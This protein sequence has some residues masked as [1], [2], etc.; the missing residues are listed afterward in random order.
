[1][2][3][4]IEA[5]LRQNVLINA[6]FIGLVAYA[7]SVALPS[8]PIDRYPNFSFGQ[9]QV[10]TRYPGASAFDVERLVTKKIEDAIRGMDDIEWVSSVS[11]FG[12]SEVLVKFI[13]DTD[14]KALYDELRLRVLS[15]QNQLPTI[16]GDP[17]SPLFS[18]IETDTWLP[19]VQVSLLN[20]DGGRSLDKRALTL[21]GRDLRNQLESIPGVKRV[22]L[23]GDEDQQFTLALNS[24]RLERYRVSFGEV[25]SALEWSGLSLPAGVARTSAGERTIVVDSRYRAPEEVFDVV[26]RRDGDGAFLKVGDL[27]DEGE[28]GI[29][30]VEGALIAT[31]NGRPAV[32][33]KVLKSP[34][35]NAFEIHEKVVER[36]TEF[37]EVHADK[38]LDLV[39]TLD[40]TVKIRDSMAVLYDSLMLALALVI[41]T[42][43]FFMTH[44]GVFL[45]IVGSILGVTAL[46]VIAASDRPTLEFTALGALAIFVF[47]AC[48]SAILT[49]A[50]IDFSFLG[51][52]V[53]FYL[54]G[55]SLNE[56]SLL[57]FVLTCGI[58]VD[59]AI[60]VLENIQRHRE[61]GSTLW[62]AAADGTQEVFW[63][64]VSATL[65]TCAA[66]LPMLIMT[67]STGDFFAI[68]PITVATAL[69]ISLVECLLMLPLHAIE[70]ERVLGPEKSGE[71]AEDST[72]GLLARRGLLG[73]AGRIYYGI[74]D[75][76][77]RHKAPTL[78]FAAVL[79]AGAIGIVA[80]SLMGP[81]R[82]EAP[83]LKLR[84]FPED[85]S[86]LNITLRTPAGSSIEET[87]RIVREISEDLIAH[88][89]GVIANST[90][91]AGMTVDTTFR[92]VWNRR[93]GFLLV[94][95]P[96]REDRE[97][98][99]PQLLIEELRRELTQKYQPRGVQI[100]VTAQKDGPPT[101]ASL[102][103]RAEGENDQAVAQL[104]DDLYAWLAQE[105][106]D[107]GKL[108]GLI[109]LKHDRELF[110]QQIRFVP[111]QE[112]MAR[113]GL[114]ADR[115]Q[116]FVAGA[117]EGAFV[118]DYLRSD[119]EIP[120]RVRLDSA[121]VADVTGVLNIPL[122]LDSSG[123][124]VRFG[125]LG[126]LEA[127]VE[128]SSL[129]RRDFRRVI[130]IEGN[131]ADSA[132]LSA[133]A[134]T[135][136][137]EA[138]YSEHRFDYPGAI[139]SFGGEAEHTQKSFESLGLAF[140]VALFVIYLILATQ[141]SS[142]FQPLIILSNVAFSF[143][144][145]VLLMALLAFLGSFLPDWLAREERTM[146]T[147][148]SMIALVGL[149]GIVVNDAI[150]LIDFINKRVADGWEISE[151]VRLA[152]LQRMR[153]VLMTTISTMAGL[154][155]MALGIPYFSTS[156]TPFATCFISGLLFSTT[157][158][159]LI[160]P[161]LYELLYLV[162]GPKSRKRRDDDE[163]DAA[164]R[165]T[166]E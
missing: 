67:G 69:A 162:L 96:A 157:M 164:S 144:G 110:E 153:P 91:L 79:F 52:L 9:A 90:G 114:R 159:L 129:R 134:L 15:V 73:R 155:P 6:V 126:R 12:Q 149:T 66:F 42:L 148:T 141:F 72:E 38:P 81:A 28:T 104:A 63:P 136:L 26:I 76:N 55:Q 112:A 160:I 127:A 85:L 5:S 36:S 11:V 70:L 17:L 25:L 54:F 93:Y 139:L 74:L 21:L 158:T 143:T 121:S 117:F 137:V 35:A 59:D 18:E 120:I 34:K 64:V 165:L 33:C 32:T 89:P 86:I 30:K 10:L 154:I 45:G 60:I 163:E 24:A 44:R 106:A 156:W 88:G 116:R 95:L 92:P 125:D 138:W 105:S 71:P 77:L 22:D 80:Q 132:A 29:R 109:D 94:E 43:F 135:D 68:L 108:K 46:V 65:T 152:G 151:A 130:R 62:R 161:V 87:D 97:Y 61:T 131:L 78:L 49:V 8:L 166:S 50:G 98:D 99:N 27:I 58:I 53:A 16:D 146:I 37:R 147:M 39:F 113:M 7:V 57:G 102:S 142:Y 4:L 1:M 103:V 3:S 140:F 82:G 20:Q 118:G 124:L 83:I 2:K 56:I 122:A 100:Q 40:S 150:V 14:Y 128:P 145:V 111:D 13:D 31:V 119:D 107:G 133:S 41:A 47:F 19:V 123:R 101:G 23:S 84:F 115:V 75:W 48:R 51:T